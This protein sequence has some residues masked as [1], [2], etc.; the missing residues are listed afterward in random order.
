MSCGRTQEK[1]VEQLFLVH[2]DA[3][4]GAAVYGVPHFMYRG[5]R[6]DHQRTVRRF[7]PFEDVGIQVY[8]SLASIAV[9]KVQSHMLCFRV[10]AHV[11][12]IIINSC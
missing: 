11:Q 1:I 10:V 9:G 6:A 4:A 3:F 7:I 5:F 2:E 8:T 12:I